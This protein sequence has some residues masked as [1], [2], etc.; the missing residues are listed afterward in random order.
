M[1]KI[2]NH[3]KENWIRYGF[4]TFVVINSIL[5]A[6]GLTNWNENRKSANDQYESLDKLK[7]DLEY[8]IKKLRG[9]DSIYDEWNTHANFIL[10][11]ILSG[12]TEEINSLEEITVGR[13]SMNHIMI[14]KTTYNEMLNTGIFFKISNKD[15]TQQ[16]SDYY[17]TGNFEINKLD[18]DNQNLAD[19]IMSP[20]NKDQFTM[21]MRLIE[22]RNLDYLNWDWLKN[23]DSEKYQKLESTTIYM[24]SAIYANQLVIEE[25]IQKAENTIKSVNAH[26]Q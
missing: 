18:R 8:D 9:M 23:P 14:K 11:E 7:L 17:E 20:I 25:L 19:Y 15:L 21:V 24:K 6:F 13:G 2:L 5:I 12:T 3:L 1:N 22:Q 4:E 16:I 10:S 26:Q